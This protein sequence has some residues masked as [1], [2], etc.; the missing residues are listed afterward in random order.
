MPSLPQSEAH[1]LGLIA[2]GGWGNRAMRADGPM[3]RA[4]QQSPHTVREGN[5]LTVE[6]ASC[7]GLALVEIDDREYD[8]TTA[9]IGLAL[10]EM[11]HREDCAVPLHLAALLAEMRT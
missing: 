9:E 5:T 8:T 4:H 10:I 11:K 7:G 6:C 2:S 1:K 3:A